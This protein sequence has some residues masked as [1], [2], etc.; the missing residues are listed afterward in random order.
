MGDPGAVPGG[1]GLALGDPGAMPGGRGLALGDP[2]AL[3]Q[4]GPWSLPS[5]HG[6]AHDHGSLPNTL[7]DSC[8][9]TCMASLSP[10]M[11]C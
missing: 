1:R 10:S 3:G 5:V 2:G 9:S 7:A 4:V 6:Q 11:A 8:P